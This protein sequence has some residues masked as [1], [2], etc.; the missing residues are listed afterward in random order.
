GPARSLF[1]RSYPDGRNRACAPTLRAPRRDLSRP[2]AWR[3]LADR[4]SE[5]RQ[6]LRPALR[7]EGLRHVAGS[8][9]D[10]FFPLLDDSAVAGLGLSASAC[11]QQ[12]FYAENLRRLWPG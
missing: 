12:G 2:P 6:P 5:L 3:S 4:H 1:R 10:L 11:R 7:T 9:R 8:A